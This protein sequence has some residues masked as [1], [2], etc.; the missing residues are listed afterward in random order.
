MKH[1]MEEKIDNKK[2]SFYFATDILLAN[3]LVE[4]ESIVIKASP[5]K[6]I[7]CSKGKVLVRTNTHVE[8]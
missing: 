8:K 6:S 2:T 3:L 1:V 4:M 5:R 7:W